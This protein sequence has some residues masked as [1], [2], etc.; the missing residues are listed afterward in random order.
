MLPRNC[1]L[2]AIWK[3]VPRKSAH[4]AAWIPHCRLA[5][6]TTM[7][8]LMDEGVPSLPVFD[9]IIVPQSKARLATGELYDA[10]YQRIGKR[11]LLKTKSELPGVREA[12][13]SSPRPLSWAACGN[14]GGLPPLRAAA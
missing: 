6:L 8:K 7:M 10:F 1:A 14:A 12:T 4:P 2:E 5:I 11:P 9:S 13:L 3:R